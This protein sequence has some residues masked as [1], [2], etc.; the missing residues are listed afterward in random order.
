MNNTITER[1]Y[2]FLKEFPPFNALEYAQLMS[3]CENVKVGYYEKDS[4]VFN[5]DEELH[6]VFYV[7]KD[8][9]I[10]IYRG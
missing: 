6:D 5:T 4:L 7:V 9:A 8:G 10:G 3:I 2:D 1:I